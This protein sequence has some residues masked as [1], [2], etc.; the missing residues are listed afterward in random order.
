VLGLEGYGIEIVDQVPI[1]AG[2][3]ASCEQ[4]GPDY[5]VEEALT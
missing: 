5:R 3:G 4:D 1:T 2:A